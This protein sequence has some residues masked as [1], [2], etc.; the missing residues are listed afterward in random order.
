[1]RRPLV[2]AVLIGIEAVALG[3][4][5][6]EPITG[7]WR[8]ESQEVNGEKGE[9]EPMTL[10]VTLT[11]D[12]YSFAFSVPVNKVYFVSMSY[13]V[14][15]DGSEADVLNSQGKKIGTVQMS[16]AE[17]S[18]YRLILKASNRR[19]SDGLIT[20]SP[21]AKKLTSESDAVQAGRVM[22]SKQVFSR[23]Q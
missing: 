20:V 21:D 10:K 9:A 16:I 22:H 14:R 4:G 18:K 3:A 11:G 15:L 5:A 17:P 23:Y 7:T 19:P 1:M 8:L 2:I 6:P 13:T 12:R